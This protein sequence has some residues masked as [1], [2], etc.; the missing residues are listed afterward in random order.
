M[1]RRPTRVFVALG[2][3]GIT[4]LA[5]NLRT[6]VSSFSPIAHI[7]GEEI[8]LSPIALGVI[9]MLPPLV[10]ALAGIITPVLSRRLSLEAIVVASLAVMVAGFALRSL[11]T[12]AW[13][14]GLGT[15]IALL[16]M[17][18]G[19]V[20]M[21]AIVK[22]R[23]PKHIGPLS[24]F[25]VIVIAVSAFLPPLFAAQ[26]AEGQGWR[27]SLAFWGAVAACSVIPWII[28]W[29]TDRNSSAIGS[30]SKAAAPSPARSRTAWTIVALFGVCSLGSYALFAWLPQLLVEFKGLDPIAAN[31]QLSLYAILGVPAALIAPAIVTNGRFIRP[32]AIAGVLLWAGGF[33]VILLGP[34]SAVTWG[35]AMTGLGQ[36][37][38][39]MSLTLIGVR[40]ATVAGAARLSS[41][42][43]G[44][45]YMIAATGPL[46]V[47]ILQSLTGSW[48]P[49]LVFLVVVTLA[50]L[51]AALLVDRPNDYEAGV[52]APAERKA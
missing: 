17:G 50:A 10:F 3:L 11:A 18:I 52:T 51:P 35:V 39:P 46:I 7:V 16:G 23:F 32:A 15:V 43:Q 28:L 27:I 41:F 37:L 34:A 21:P 9:G 47:S 25:Y 30:R 26:L 13:T 6:A 5:L 42:V 20:L 14:I 4:L 38:F 36:L 29:A 22:A 48:T 45:A 44:W 2:L 19:N 33:L 1:T 31:L 49:A 8:P 24:S 40:A 12:S